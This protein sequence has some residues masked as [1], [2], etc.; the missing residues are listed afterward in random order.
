MATP[1]KAVLQVSTAQFVR[2]LTTSIGLV[3]R[4]STAVLAL[5]KVILALGA[6][7]VAVTATAIAFARSQALLIDRI[8]KVASVTGF[9][10]QQ[11]QALR[12]AAEVAGVSSDQ[13]DVALRRFSRRLGEAARGTGELLPALR[14]LNIAVRDGEGNIRDEFE[15]LKDFADGIKRTKSE[16]AQLSLAFKAFDSEGAELVQ[17]LVNGRKCLLAF[18]EAQKI[19]NLEIT[20]RS[21]SRI[22]LLND[23]IFALQL[24]FKKVTAEAIGALA[25]ALADTLLLAMFKLKNIIAETEGGMEG[26]AKIVASKFLSAIQGATLGLIQFFNILV[27]VANGVMQLS[28]SLN[29]PGT[30]LYNLRKNLQEFK[31]IEGKGFLDRMT[32]I[33]VTSGRTAEILEKKLG[34][35][36]LLTKDNVATA[37]QTI[38]AEI[39]RLEKAGQADI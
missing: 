10:T 1:I 25:P 20:E 37:I 11:L 31:D 36:F 22:E 24:E 39:E 18:F 34:K 6:G 28:S 8:G 7:F 2:G 33:S 21:I 30:E 23:T 14:R 29:L 3:G 35:G 38:E 4:L 13:L 15:V 9:T 19:L 5:S 12:F 17:T 16:T 26:F 32:T 27:P